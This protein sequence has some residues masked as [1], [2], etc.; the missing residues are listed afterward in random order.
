MRV[1]VVVTCYQRHDYLREAVASVVRQASDVDAEVVVLKDWSDPALDESMARDGVSVVTRDIPV[2]GE[3]MREGIDRSTGDVVCFLDDDDAF[4]PGKLRAVRAA[5]EQDPDLVL[6]RNGF[7]PVD[8]TGVPLDGIRRILPQPRRPFVVDTRDVSLTE[9]VRIVRGRALF[10]LSTF[11]VRRRALAA[12]AEPL[13]HVEAA[14]DMALATLLLDEPG[15]CRID[16]RPWNRRRI[17]TSQRTYGKGGEAGRLLRT[18]EYLR[19]RARSD[20]AVWFAEYALALARVE[21]FLN[22]RPD[23]FTYGDWL[24]YVWYNLARTDAALWESEA[25]SLAKL[26]GL[27]FLERRRGVP[28]SA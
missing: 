14:T 20:A 16:P 4:A 6:V 27:P 21:A 22:S 12:G 3:M 9:R 28:R 25:R 23:R 17:G 24:T 18:F 2:V 15:R 13:R 8:G 1:S 5:F 10:N 7:V 11:S 26:L 19:P